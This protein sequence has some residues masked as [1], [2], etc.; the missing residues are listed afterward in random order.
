MA[1]GTAYLALPQETQGLELPQALPLTP[2][3]VS[4]LPGSHLG[5][6]KPAKEIL[7]L[8]FLPFQAVQIQGSSSAFFSN[9]T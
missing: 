8:L 1:R 7:T 3:S 6:I 9:Y 2:N 5:G 4:Y